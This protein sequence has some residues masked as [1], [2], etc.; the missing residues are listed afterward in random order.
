MT[1]SVLTKVEIT[2]NCGII[3]VCP[4]SK[5]TVI[6]QNIKIWL[7]RNIFTLQIIF[8]VMKWVSHSSNW[9]WNKTLNKTDFCG[10]RWL[11]YFHSDGAVCPLVIK[12]DVPSLGRYVGRYVGKKVNKKIGGRLVFQERTHAPC[13]LTFPIFMHTCNCLIVYL[14][15]DIFVCIYNW[16]PSFV[17]LCLYLTNACDKFHQF[18]CSSTLSASVRKSFSRMFRLSVVT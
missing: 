10:W 6:Y 16:F 1:L 18:L 12:S 7:M 3:F 2:I 4:A 5:S 13:Y 14:F 17:Y 11:L 15:V 9:I 8:C